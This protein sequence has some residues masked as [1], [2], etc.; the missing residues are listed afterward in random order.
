MDDYEKNSFNSNEYDDD[1][2][3]EYYEDD[4]QITE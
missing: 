3:Y 4:V 1:D 2:E